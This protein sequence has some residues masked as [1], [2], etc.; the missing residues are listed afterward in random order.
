MQNISPTRFLP[1]PAPDLWLANHDLSFIGLDKDQYTQSNPSTVDK[2]GRNTGGKIKQWS[3]Q[4]I[5]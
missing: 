5:K 3:A 2:T 4:L 1:H